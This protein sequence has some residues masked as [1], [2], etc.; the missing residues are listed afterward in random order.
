[1]WCYIVNVP[2]SGYL[3]LNKKLQLERTFTICTSNDIWF[4]TGG[5]RALIGTTAAVRP[6]AR[7]GEVPADVISIA[8]SRTRGNRLQGGGIFSW[9]RVGIQSWP[10]GKIGAILVPVS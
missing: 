4:T 10:F 3:L 1:M 7:V 6:V 8:T 5:D 2:A 9:S